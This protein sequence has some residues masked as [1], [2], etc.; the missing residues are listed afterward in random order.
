MEILKGNRHSIGIKTFL[1]IKRAMVG[2]SRE[3]IAPLV[4]LE[5]SL[6]MYGISGFVPGDLVRI[7][8]LPEN[9]RNNVYW[10]IMEVSHNLGDTWS[11]TLIISTI[12]IKPFPLKSP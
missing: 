9:Y 12:F 3:K 1:Y 10:Q 8:Y 2:S 4:E 5:A 7:N 11:T 6:E